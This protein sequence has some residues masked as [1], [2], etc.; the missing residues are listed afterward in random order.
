MNNKESTLVNSGGKIIVIEFPR[1]PKATLCHVLF[2]FFKKTRSDVDIA[3]IVFVCV[4]GG[5]YFSATITL[6][7]SGPWGGG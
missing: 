6:R 5:V 2:G 3:S 1:I 7:S 4:C